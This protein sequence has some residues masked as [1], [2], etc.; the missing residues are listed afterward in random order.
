M[1]WPV[2][3]HAS[4][5]A[6]V[7]LLGAAG[8][9]R[10]AGE[11]FPP[12]VPARVWPAAPDRPRIRW[13]GA[14]RGSEDLHAGQSGREVWASFLRGPRPPIRFSTPH[15]IAI[16]DD[17]LLAVA[18][19]GAA[20]VHIVDLSTREHTLVSG[21][22]NEQFAMPIGVA[23]AQKR[24]FVSDA[25]RHEV[26]ELSASGSFVNRFGS[27]ELTRPVGIAF[28]DKLAALYVVD[29][30]AHHIAVFDLHGVLQ[31]TIGRR[32]EQPG[33][34]NYPSYLSVR[35]G[36]MLVADSGNF[37]VQLLDLDGNVIRTI[38]QK[39][40]GAGDFALPKGVAIDS[41]GHLFVVDAQ[42][43]NVQVFDATG[44]L[45]LAFGNEGRS[46]GEFRLPAAVAIDSRDRIWVADSGNRRIQLFSQVRASS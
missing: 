19:G 15:A 30:G 5:L 25:Q 18:D 26:I 38:G 33:Q 27:K 7:V 10:P 2:V 20:A 13:V 42:F 29:G 37:R 44:Q 8:C 9:A 23:W 24:L 6:V 28:V 12:T 11:L 3:K 4:A 32:G 21:F 46:P 31:K 43:E 22:G 45:L 1:C 35:D 17:T 40:N 34:F 14:L 39:G 41:S 16:S 36:R